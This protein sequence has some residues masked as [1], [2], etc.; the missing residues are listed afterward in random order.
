[1]RARFASARV[2]RVIGL[3]IVALAAGV[4]TG[5]AGDPARYLPP[6]GAPYGAEEVGVR[7]QELHYLS[8]TLTAPYDGKRHPAVV[9]IS[10]V[11]RHDRDQAP[12]Q[13]SPYRPFFQIADTLSRRGFAV[14]R[15]DDRGVGASTGSLDSA[16]TW[17]RSFDTRAAVEYLRKRPDINKHKIALLGIGEGGAIAPMIAADDSLLACVVL[18]A[19]PA[20][21]GRDLRAPDHRG[22]Q[23]VRDTNAARHD[24]TAERR[25]TASARPPNLEVIVGADP[26]ARYFSGY[27]PLATARRVRVP[28]LLL[29]GAAD[30][31]VPPGDTEL[32]AAAMRGA[33]NRSVTTKI[34][35]GLGHDFL[36]VGE[37]TGALAAADS[38]KVPAVVLGAIADWLVKELN[39][40]AEPKVPPPPAHRSRHRH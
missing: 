6:P 17:D 14:L 10:D 12:S 16:T 7:S 3:A 11:G 38:V 30:R 2:T 25:D 37:A 36:R 19:A 29:H 31:V 32:L 28:A 34:F 21:E 24:S 26:W 1:M 20:E 13:L 18:M 4:G 33:G 35:D 22:P 5:R 8:G 9:L 27:E 40:A 15:L 23:G 39:P